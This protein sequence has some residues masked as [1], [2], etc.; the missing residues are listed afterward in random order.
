MATEAKGMRVNLNGTVTDVQFKDETAR[1]TLSQQQTAISKNTSD[2]TAINS[3]L[4]NKADANR[5]WTPKSLP[6]GFNSN[7]RNSM[8]TLK[9]GWY[10]HTPNDGTWNFPTDY[11]F[12]FKVSFEDAGYDFNA[13][14]FGQI[15]GSIYRCSGNGTSISGWIEI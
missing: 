12:M 6:S 11:G 9:N 2:I 5:I 3:S 13:I 4:A 10:W 8:A 1:N 15:S 14:Y 7:D